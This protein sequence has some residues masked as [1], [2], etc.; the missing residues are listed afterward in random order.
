MKRRKRKWAWT[1]TKSW[2]VQSATYG[3][4]LKIISGIPIKR[5]CLTT[6]R[7]HSLTG[8]HWIAHMP[9]RTCENCL[10]NRLYG[11]K[12]L[13]RLLSMEHGQ[14]TLIIILRI[15]SLMSYWNAVD[16]VVMIYVNS[17]YSLARKDCRMLRRIVSSGELTKSHRTH[18][19]QAKK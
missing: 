19:S 11:M 8:W 9:S 5:K 1:W 4:Q 12:I 3:K 17:R 10:A 2:N 14:T 6:S 15:V 7:M 13:M 16:S 18:T